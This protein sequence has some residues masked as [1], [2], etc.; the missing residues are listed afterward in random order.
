[1]LELA[2]ASW[3]GLQNALSLSPTCTQLWKVTVGALP[4]GWSLL[5][6]RGWGLCSAGS[7]GQPSLGGVRELPTYPAPAAL[8]VSPLI[9]NSL[10]CAARLSPG[11]ISMWLYYP[12]SSILTVVPWTHVW[13]KTNPSRPSIFPFAFVST[14][15]RCQ[16][17]P[18]FT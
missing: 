1:M 8:Q 12:L 13:I 2:A 5:P 10:C 16:K 6:R 17:W 9:Q 3:A 7:L 18:E 14:L 4:P 11:N 15:C